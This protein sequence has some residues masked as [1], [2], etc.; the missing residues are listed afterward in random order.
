[1]L[2]RNE[3]LEACRYPSAIVVSGVSV[4]DGAKSVHCL[5]LEQDVN[6]DQVGRPIAG[7]LV[8]E[9]GIALGPA[10]QLVEKVDHHL[11]QGNPVLEFDPLGRQVRHLVK[12]PSAGLTQLHQGPRVLGWCDDARQQPRLLD[13]FQLTNGWHVAWIV[14]LDDRSVRPNSPVLHRRRRCDQAEVKLPFQ[15]LTDDLHVKEAQEPTAEPEAQGQGRFRFI[16]EAGV[17]EP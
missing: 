3:F 12:F 7:G 17:V 6:P 2:A 15:A 10:L 14:D 16:G 11:S 5:S 1:M 13:T 8:V 4:D 9:A